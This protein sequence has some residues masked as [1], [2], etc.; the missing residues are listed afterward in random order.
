MPQIRAS[1]KEGTGLYLKAYYNPP[2]ELL[3][4]HKIMATPIIIAAVIVAP[5]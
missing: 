4:R 2:L 3:E 1:S 5:S